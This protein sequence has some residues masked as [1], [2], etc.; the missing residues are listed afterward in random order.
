MAIDDA[1]LRAIIADNRAAQA[2]YKPEPEYWT[3]ATVAA[4]FDN[5]ESERLLRG[6]Q[7][8]LTDRER[9]EVDRIMRQYDPNA[10]D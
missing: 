9:S 6:E 2:A 7:R 1:R 3:D 5:P 4:I 8:K 10:T